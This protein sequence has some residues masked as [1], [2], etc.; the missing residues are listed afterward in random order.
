MKTCSC[1]FSCVSFL[2]HVGSF[3]LCLGGCLHSRKNLV[4]DSCGFPSCVTVAP[5]VDDF[6]R[7]TSGTSIPRVPFFAKLLDLSGPS[8]HQKNHKQKHEIVPKSTKIRPLGGL[9]GIFEKKRRKSDFRWILGVPF[10]R[11][12]GSLFDPFIT[13]GG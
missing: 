9:G 12:L 11:I 5:F 3:L 10:M 1:R 4:P 6:L 8:S 7:K 13:S 2:F